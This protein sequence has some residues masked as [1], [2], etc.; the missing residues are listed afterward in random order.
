M[1]SAEAVTIL[2]SVTAERSAPDPLLMAS[3]LS[4]LRRR[5]CA[6]A[7]VPY[8]YVSAFR[9]SDD[10]VPGLVERGAQHFTATDLAASLAGS[11]SNPA[12]AIFGGRDDLLSIGAESGAAHPIR[13]PDDHWWR[14]RS[15]ECPNPSCR[16]IR[17]ADDP[18]SVSTE[19][20]A[21]NTFFM[22]PDQARFS[23]HRPPDSGGR[24]VRGREYSGAV[25]AERDRAHRAV[26]P[27]E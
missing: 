10:A 7:D 23:R 11:E 3:Q 13:V 14:C 6:V 9:G 17:G 22:L 2:L 4:F 15:I 19:G 21:F 16:I 5:R 24:V 1:R 27:A 20:D 8:R 26:M 25:G 12:P 18:G